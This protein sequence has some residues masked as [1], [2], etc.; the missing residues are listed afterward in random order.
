MPFRI[1]PFVNEAQ[2]WRPG[3]ADCKPTVTQ[4]QQL[5]PDAARQE[6]RFIVQALKELVLLF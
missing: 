1:R 5:Q 3:I 2:K 6:L 4:R